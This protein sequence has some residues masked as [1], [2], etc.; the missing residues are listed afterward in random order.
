ME[1]WNNLSTHL[2]DFGIEYGILSVVPLLKIPDLISIGIPIFY[3][4][5][6]L[7]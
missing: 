6:E 5:T 2:L 4:S 1:F 7:Y 3:N